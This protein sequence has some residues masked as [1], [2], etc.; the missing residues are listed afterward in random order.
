MKTVLVAGATGYLGQYLVAELLRQGYQVRALV[1]NP[2]KLAQGKLVDM[3]HRRLT[4]FEAEMTEPQSLKQCC[5]GVDVVISTVGITRQKDGL[6]YE[7]V[8]YRGNLNLLRV[9]QASQNDPLGGVK[10]FLYVSVFKGEQLQNIAIGRAKEQ[11]V[12]ELKDS[13]LDHCVI[14]PNGFFSDVKAFFELA[15][16]G[17]GF[18]FGNGQF[19]SNPIHGA[20]L[21][22]VCVSAITGHDTEI[23]VGGPEVLTQQAIV[24]LAFQVQGKPVRLHHIPLW[25][26]PLTITFGKF[27]LGAKAFG[28]VEFFLTVMTM[29]M[30]APTVGRHTLKAFFESLNTTEQH[31][32]DEIKG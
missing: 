30:V 2:Q 4:L 11:F 16:Q 9:A 22:E 32:Y 19:R 8:D 17:R 13:G 14:R 25:I 27:F 21:A 24:E 18:V 20:D 29:D 6:T 23:E 26:K 7:D 1:R 31:E 15:T 10:K 28:P 3:H 5:E 12:K